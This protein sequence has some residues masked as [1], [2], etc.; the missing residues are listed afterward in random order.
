MKPVSVI[1]QKSECS[2]VKIKRTLKKT[3]ANFTLIIKKIT[4]IARSMQTQKRKTLPDP[5]LDV[6]AVVIYINFFSANRIEL[7]KI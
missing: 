1:A 3:L 4:Q 5:Y 6:A 7:I 2:S